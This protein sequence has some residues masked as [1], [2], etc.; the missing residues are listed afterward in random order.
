MSCEDAPFSSEAFCVFPNTSVSD[1][2]VCSAVMVLL[3]EE[4]VNQQRK[5]GLHFCKAFFVTLGFYL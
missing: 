4:K 5:A 1:L 3:A 2:V